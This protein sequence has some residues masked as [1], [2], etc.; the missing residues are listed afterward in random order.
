MTQVVSGVDEKTVQVFL[1]VTL[2]GIHF[3]DNINCD[4]LWEKVH[5]RAYFQ[6]RVIGTTG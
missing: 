3:N 4:R 2:T 5:C 1:F 6:N